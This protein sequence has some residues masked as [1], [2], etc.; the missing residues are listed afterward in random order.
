MYKYI[1]YLFLIVGISCQNIY[2]TYTAIDAKKTRTAKI[3][4]ND[5]ND[6]NEQINLMPIGYENY[7]R[8]LSSESE[9]FNEEFR[10]RSFCALDTC[11]CDLFKLCAASCGCGILIIL[12]VIAK[13][14][15]L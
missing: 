6:N 14:Y 13:V 11:Q 3:V 7:M 8:R 10:S 2:S 15:A 12:L 5:Q 9:S 1:T 4:L